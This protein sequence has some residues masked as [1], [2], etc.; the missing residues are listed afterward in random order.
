[1]KK[2]NVMEFIGASVFN[3]IVEALTSLGIKKEKVTKKKV[4]SFVIIGGIV[5]FCEFGIK[6]IKKV[7]RKKMN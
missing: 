3:A 2:K 7:I 1:M 5:A 6:S 4:I